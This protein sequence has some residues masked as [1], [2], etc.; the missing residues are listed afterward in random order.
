[1]IRNQHIH[2]QSTYQAARA[3]WILCAYHTFVYY[4]TILKFNNFD[5]FQQLKLYDLSLLYQLGL[6][7]IQKVFW[8]LYSLSFFAII[9]VERLFEFSKRMY[10]FY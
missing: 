1:M 7:K 4:N 2:P 9:H 6:Q 5:F 3:W 8:V 10:D